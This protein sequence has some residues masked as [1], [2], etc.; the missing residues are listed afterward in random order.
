MGSGAIGIEFASFYRAMGAEVTVIE[1]LPQILPVEDAEIAAYARKTLRQARHPD[2]DR[3][4]GRTR[5]KRSRQRHRHHRTART[6]SQTLTGD[7]LI[8][9]VGV[10][11]NTEGLGLEKLGVKTQPRR[12]RHRRGR[13]DQRAGRLGHRR[14]RRAAD[15]GAQGR[16]RSGRQ[17]RNH[18]GLHPHPM[19][20]RMVPGCTYCDAANRHVGLTEA[21]ARERK[22]HPGR[23]FPVR[24]QRQGDRARRD[25]GLVKII[26]DNKTG[27]SWARTWSARK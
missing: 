17:R 11:C 26:F 14:R 6:A 5:S 23:P 16:A 22:R 25:Q 18:R 2:S 15:A 27:N 12:H 13:P 8:S 19:D 9:A 21:K 1:L 7:H 20:K 24:R 10:V 3:R 4:Q